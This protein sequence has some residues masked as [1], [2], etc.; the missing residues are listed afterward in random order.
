MKA[1][2]TIFPGIKLRGCHFHFTQCLWRKIQDVG[3]A[4]VYKQN[5]DIRMHVRKCGSMAYLPLDKIDDAWLIIQSTAPDD[6]KLTEFND[7]FVENWLD[8]ATISKEM[9]NCHDEK[10][11]TNNIVEG[12]NHKFK[13]LN[14]IYAALL[15]KAGAASGGQIT[16]KQ[17]PRT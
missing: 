17:H 11:R 12:W 10:H 7:Y 2:T 15:T 16:R 1:L 8:S 14:V 5:E 13:T 3:L 4:S 6:V 9:W